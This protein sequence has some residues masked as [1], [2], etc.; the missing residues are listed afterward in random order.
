MKNKTIKKTPTPTGNSNIIIGSWRFHLDE[1]HPYA[2]AINLFTPEE[3]E[4][5]IK[6]GEKLHQHEAT[7]S[8]KTTIDKKVRE[9]M[10]S[11]IYPGLE[12]NWIYQKIVPVINE[13]NS[14]YFGFDLDGL[15]E[16]FQ[17]TKYIAP[18]GKYTAHTD[19]GYNTGIRKLSFSLQLTDKD[20]YKGG[21][22]VFYDGK[23]TRL[24]SDLRKQ[25]VLIAFPSFNVHEVKPVTKGTRYSLVGWVGGPNFK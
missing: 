25:G 11:W 3:C 9:S 18:S 2:Y 13:L 19:R 20:K 14:K 10:V 22:L 12:T 23:Y 15:Y 5:I 6:L 7:I 17:F 24:K 21:D 16:G 4:N 1:I 8:T